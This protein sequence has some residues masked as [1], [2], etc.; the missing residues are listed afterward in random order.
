M[1]SAEPP[2]SRL[3]VVVVAPSGGGSFV[4]FTLVGG[5]VSFEKGLPSQLEV[6]ISCVAGRPTAARRIPSP[7]SMCSLPLA[8]S[9]RTVV[10]T[11]RQSASASSAV[12]KLLPDEM[13]SH[14]LAYTRRMAVDFER[15]L[16]LAASCD[17]Q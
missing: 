9:R 5:F 2:P 11:H 10:D 7:A 16:S 8:R 6:I 4:S 12:V 13:P 17:I 14:G 15:R 3:G 1:T